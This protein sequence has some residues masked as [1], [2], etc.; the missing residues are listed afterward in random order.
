MRLRADTIVLMVDETILRLFPPLRAAWAKRGAQARVEITGQNDRRV[1]FGA[2]NLLTGHRIIM[3]A[4]TQHQ[5]EFQRFL[6]HLRCAYR[7]RPVCL[8]LDKHRSHTAPATVQLA[9]Q[10]GIRLLWLPTQSPEL[11]A[12]DQL[13]RHLKQR[14]AANRQYETI[15]ELAS[16]A[17][18]W[19]LS[20]TT[21]VALRFAGIKSKNFWLRR[22][23]QNFCGNT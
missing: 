10:L 21:T 18:A 9:R 12:M 4:R 3:I 20:L 6:R 14:I 8:L 2:I 7:G 17:R 22:F 23:L 16:I 15:D 11:N 13:W 5:Q 1:L 19:M